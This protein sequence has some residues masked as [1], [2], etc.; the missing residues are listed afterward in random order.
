MEPCCKVLTFLRV[1]RLFGVLSE[2]V[3]LT[4]LMAYFPLEPELPQ[5]K[6]GV[7]SDPANWTLLPD[8]TSYFIFSVIAGADLRYRLTFESCP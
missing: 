3:P 5:L 1:N 7:L 4:G 6:P 2:D 8:S